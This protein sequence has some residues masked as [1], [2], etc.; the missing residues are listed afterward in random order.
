M[1]KKIIITFSVIV[2]CACGTTEEKKETR[3]S[4]SLSAVIDSA[5]AKDTLLLKLKNDT[6]IKTKNP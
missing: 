6:L 2:F 5:A 4:D 3:K 1:I